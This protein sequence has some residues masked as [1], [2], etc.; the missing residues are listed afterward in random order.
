MSPIKI[1]KLSSLRRHLRYFTSVTYET[2]NSLRCM[3]PVTESLFG[4]ES[5]IQRKLVTNLIIF[6]LIN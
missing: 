1:F 2:R 5:T 4:E 3:K 6:L